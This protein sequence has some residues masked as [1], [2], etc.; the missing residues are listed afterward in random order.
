MALREKCF[1]NVSLVLTYKQ[2]N[3]HAVFNQQHE[4]GKFTAI[5]I[6]IQ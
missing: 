3:G 6:K 2:Y 1:I 4:I 5:F